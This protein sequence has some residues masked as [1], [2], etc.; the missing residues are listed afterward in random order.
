MKRCTNCLLGQI[1]VEGAVEETEQIIIASGERILNT[2]TNVKKAE[3]RMVIYRNCQRGPGKT[4]PYHD[5]CIS[6]L[7]YI[8]KT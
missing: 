3:P 4:V 2:T 6:K 1:A 7:E 5:K 8:P